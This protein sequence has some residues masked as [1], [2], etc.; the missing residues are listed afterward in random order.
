MTSPAVGS[1]PWAASSLK[2][3]RKHLRTDLRR[4]GFQG[5][6]PTIVSAGSGARRLSRGSEP[7]DTWLAQGCNWR[8]GQGPQLGG[9]SET[10]RSQAHDCPTAE[11]RFREREAEAPQ[12]P[13]AREL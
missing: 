11:T 2:Q 10:P 3:L 13:L 8:L 5:L 12:L 7:G 6:G 1:G 4:V 9:R